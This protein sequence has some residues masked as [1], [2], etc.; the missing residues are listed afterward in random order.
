MIDALKK[1]V[2]W[3]TCGNNGAD[4]KEEVAIGPRKTPC[5]RV[6]LHGGAGKGPEA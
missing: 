2:I 3:I 5:R 4:D 6:D 1:R